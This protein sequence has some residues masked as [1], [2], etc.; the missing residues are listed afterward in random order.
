MATTFALLP[1]GTSNSPFANHLVRLSPCD[2]LHVW[3]IDPVSNTH[4][5]LED[6]VI[7]ISVAFIS[8]ADVSLPF[9]FFCSSKYFLQFLNQSPFL[10][11]LA[12]LSHRIICKCIDANGSLYP[13]VFKGIESLGK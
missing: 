13:G 9:F 10:W 2:D 4:Q 1:I 5:S 6:I 3:I 8:E 7:L 11:F 12:F